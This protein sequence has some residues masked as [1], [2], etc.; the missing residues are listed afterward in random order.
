[1]EIFE[2]R[3]SSAENLLLGF[4]F[5]YEKD[6]RFYAELLEEIDEWY[7]PFIF[8]GQVRAGNYSID[9]SLSL[10]FVQQRII[11]RDRQ[12][13]GS[14]LKSNKL[15]EYDEY[16]L[17][18]L[19]DG[20]CAQDE[21]FVVKT[22]E[23]NLP[24]EIKMRLDR[25]VLDVIPVNSNELIVFFRDGYTVNYS[26]K[27]NDG[28]RREFGKILTDP[29]IFERV[30]VSPGG[31]GAEWGEEH[32]ISATKLRNS[33]TPLELNYEIML[34][35]AKRRLS[36]TTESAEFMGCSRQY[37]G[38]MVREDRLHPVKMTSNNNLFLKSELER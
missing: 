20:R 14:I 30:R 9:S 24:D 17:L 2:I 3:D 32:E 8:S 35:F 37:I 1:M 36:D 26:V 13:L 38:Q 34:S 12:N 15:K 6:H 27:E 16:K 23:E 31:N 7:A 22:K 10:K 29:E 11:P 33:G 21:L 25:K 5:Y 28:D 18:C 4:L 19:S